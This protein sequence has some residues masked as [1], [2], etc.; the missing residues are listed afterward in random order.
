MTAALTLEPPA[1][2]LST[3]AAEVHVR[4]APGPR[5]VLER[6]LL[7]ASR[8]WQTAGL[9]A[10]YA[11]VLLI[12]IG[13]F[14]REQVLKALEYDP[15]A[16]SWAGR[17]IFEGY[18]FV[19]CWMLVLLTPIL[20]AQGIIEERNAGTLKL[21]A[22][23]RLTPRRLLV[24]K[25][26]SRLL[27]VEAVVLA[28]LPFLAL[29][30]SLGGVGPGQVLNVFLQANAMMLGLAG[31]TCFVSLYASGPIIP[32]IAAWIWAF[33]AWIPGGLPMAT[34]R[35]DE[36]DMAWVSPLVS[37]FEGEGLAMIGPLLVAAVVVALCMQ[38]S[39]RVFATLAG[40]DTDG[41]HLSADVWAVERTGRRIGMLVAG[42][43]VSMPPLAV[44]WAFAHRSRFAGE[45]LVMPAMW[46]WNLL[47]ITAATG[48]YL[49]AVRAAL[50]WLSQARARRFGWRAQIEAWQSDPT[51]IGSGSTAR[52]RNLSQ[53]AVGEG[54][55]TQAHR[56]RFLRPVWSNP[57]AWREVVTAV[58]GGFSGFIG[59]GYAAIAGFL[60]LLC[61][62]PDFVED[63]EGPL[64]AAF[65]ALAVAWVATALA[66]ASSASGE[67]RAR[68]LALLV[69][70]RMSASS[71]VAG[72]VAGVLAVAGPA[73]L[74]AIVLLIGGVGQYSTA[75]RW[76]WDDDV[77][78]PGVLMHRWAAMSAFAVAVTAWFATSNLW[79]GLRARTPGRAWVL[80]LLNVAAWVFVPAVLR[81]MVHGSDVLVEPL[82]LINPALGENFWDDAAVP[83]GIWASTAL[84]IG[85]SAGVFA[86]AAATLPER[87]SR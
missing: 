21:L 65:M 43:F 6:E 77:F 17:R 70:S 1:G 58:H 2:D 64:A 83:A 79:L 9:R 7:R 30:L 54:R 27:M 63:P 49:L 28:G 68:C 32:A 51:P 76:D 48:V 71:I 24:G 13:F 20:V 52:P 42:L 23:T 85:M 73:L 11:A 87:A 16:L 57:V 44:A 39:A 66:A 59:W 82:L 84:W 29:C 31:V 10:S 74:L 61:L 78:D 8:R 33:L 81:A 38:M 69:T 50:R 25:L 22:I 56:P 86:H 55:R 60:V 40:G 3:P 35:G 47:A 72:K 46:I 14:W 36:D 80:C 15:T 62:V 5:V 45:W 41:E 75:Y 67:L 18:T 19:Q 53:H 34:W 37:L 4:R 26:A 12:V